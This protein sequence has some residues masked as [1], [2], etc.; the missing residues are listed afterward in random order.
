[1]PGGHGSTFSQDGA[2]RGCFLRPLL[3]LSC[4]RLSQ[5]G[6]LGK[7]TL[8]WKQIEERSEGQGLPKGREKSGIGQK[9]LLV[10]VHAVTTQASVNPMGLSG[11][12][13]LGTGTRAT[14]I[15]H[16]RELTS[17]RM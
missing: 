11:P 4:H 15:I 13:G 10:C 2:L 14:G 5:V 16:L 7:Q 8:K 3:R 9:E 17:H 1:M 12:K 6:F